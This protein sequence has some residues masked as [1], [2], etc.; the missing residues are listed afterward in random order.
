MSYFSDASSTSSAPPLTPSP[1][2]SGHLAP[3]PYS[4]PTPYD[5]ISPP[6]SIRQYSSE[7]VRKM[8]VGLTAAMRDLKDDR[9]GPERAFDVEYGYDEDPI[10]R[11]VRLF[12]TPRK[13]FDKS[14]AVPELGLK[15]LQRN[16]I[17][18]SSVPP[19]PKQHYPSMMNAE[20]TIPS[21]APRLVNHDDRGMSDPSS[22]DK[23]EYGSIQDESAKFRPGLIHFHR[24]N[25]S[26]LDPPRPS[27]SRMD[28]TMSTGSTVS[29]MSEASFEA[30]KAE[31]IVS[32]YGGG[33]D[34]KE[35]PFEYDFD[36][37]DER[38][39][40]N[41][42]EEEDGLEIGLGRSSIMSTETSNTIR[43]SHLNQYG[44]YQMS[45]EPITT[46]QYSHQHSQ[47]HS[48]SQQHSHQHTQS[49]SHSHSHYQAQAQSQTQQRAPTLPSRPSFFRKKSRVHPY[50]SPSAGETEEPPWLA[51]RTVSEQ[52]VAQAGL[53][54]QRQ[55]VG[56]NRR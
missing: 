13:V 52:M 50:E 4:S 36:Q 1:Y 45:S 38:I 46:N 34:K 44:Y 18:S 49:H 37:I 56:A 19:P 51:G 29:M 48:Q 55:R 28:S 30:V 27:Y 16:N 11:H 20:R 31:D 53:R 41:D 5:P 23:G 10:E 25:S 3:N 15:P 14:K 17:E 6:N 35:D 22:R 24:S 12:L 21:T 8:S 7:L 33:M 43:P 54:C 9:G 47:S 32:M 42:R 40:E 39:K 26:S 2:Q